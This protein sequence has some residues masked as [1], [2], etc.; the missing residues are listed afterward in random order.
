MKIIKNATLTLLIC[1]S[2]FAQAGL[3]SI[4]DAPQDL[5]G[6]VIYI[7]KS[8]DERVISETTIG[9]FSDDVR[10]TLT[11]STSGEHLV[12]FLKPSEFRMNWLCSGPCS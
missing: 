7:A 11:N 4:C 10:K 1:N 5:N 2:F 6:Y 3:T 9:S 8:I 12:S